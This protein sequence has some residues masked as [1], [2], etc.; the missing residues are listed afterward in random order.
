MTKI[1]VEHA[2]F[3]RR[4]DE[5][6]TLEARSPGFLDA[7]R[8]EA[9]RIVV[10]FGPRS[11]AFPAAG[12]VFALPLTSGQ[13]AVVR[14]AGREDGA[15]MF[16][17]LAMARPAY[18]R[19]AGDPFAVARLL[20]A[21]WEARGELPQLAWP[22]SP[23]PARTVTEV[24]EVLR[25]VKASA[26]AE[27]EDPEA[28][29][30]ERTEENSESPALLGGAQVLV[31]GGKLVF[32]RPQGDLALV[33]G[34]W[35][36]LPYSTR[37]KLWPTSFAYSDELGFDVIVLPRSNDGL[38]GYTDE[39]QAALYPQG[40]YELALQTAA[41]SGDQAALDA[42]FHRR[43]SSEMVR[44]ALLLLIGMILLVIGSRWFVPQQ[45]ETL[46]LT[47]QHQKVAAAAGLVAAGDPWATVVELGKKLWLQNETH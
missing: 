27:D 4:D 3:N 20:P 41:E 39:E 5:V 7:W 1:P 17:F 42:V 26:L 33:E 15:L 22:D 12:V 46:A 2:L 31:D 19:Y 38:A 37:C 24:R 43:N 35:T 9:E 8:G 36:L 21:T 10:G 28:P 6:A 13:V 34:L 18:E 14:V 25:R 11:G 47:E 40:S 44:L 29:R 23:L 45:P 30:F 32:V 16:H